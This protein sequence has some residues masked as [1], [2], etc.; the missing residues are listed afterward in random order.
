MHFSEFYRYNVITK[1]LKLPIAGSK[2]LD[3][4]SNDG[5][6]LSSFDAPMRVA[7]DLEPVEKQYFP[8][9]PSDAC[10]L[11]FADNSFDTVL[12]FD[13]LEHVPDDVAL[14]REGIRVLQ[15]GG[16]LWFSTPSLH[17]RLWP[18]ILMKRA[19]RAW[20]HVRDGYTPE[21]LRQR[22]PAG[23]ELITWEWN[24]PGFRNSYL[25]MRLTKMV[26]PGLARTIAQQ[27]AQWDASR[28]KGNRGHLFGQIRKV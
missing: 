23:T 7:I 10:A 13:V 4:G 5:F 25:I 21:I 3:V 24:E 9:W 16:V 2:I 19:N 27:V 14:L 26:S 11:P 28:A 20:G 22:M 17:F 1:H 8:V 18:A 15:P 6:I 12:A